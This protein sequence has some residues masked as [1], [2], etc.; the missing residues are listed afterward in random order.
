MHFF[1]KSNQLAYGLKMGHKIKAIR[2]RLDTIAVDR[3]FH[4][5][6]RPRETQVSNRVRETHHFVRAEDVIGRG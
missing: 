2:E 1:S 5:E 3:K 6:E 4:L